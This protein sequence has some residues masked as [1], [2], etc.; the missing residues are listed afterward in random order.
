LARHLRIKEIEA[1]KRYIRLTFAE[2]PRLD[3]DRV[4]QLLLEGKVRYRPEN[5]LEMEVDHEGPERQVELLKNL[6]QQLG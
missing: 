2:K 5:I 4:T 6:L 1:R 3:P